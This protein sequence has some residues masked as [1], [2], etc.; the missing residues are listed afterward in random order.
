MSFFSTFFSKNTIA[1]AVE[2]SIDAVIKIDRHNKITYANP[3]AERL[4]GYDAKEMLGHNV[5]MLVPEEFRANHDTWVNANRET[6]VNKIVGTSREVQLQRKN[7]HRIWVT[8]SLSKVVVG[9]SIEYTAFVRDITDQK[10]QREIINQTL[11]Q[12][13][14]AVVTIDENNCITFYNPAAERLWGYKADEVMGKNVKMLV[15]IHHQPKHDNYVN[16]NRNT[17]IDKIVGTAREVQFTHR[18]G[19]ERWASLSLSKIQ[20][21]DRILYTAFLRDITEEV[22]RRERIR[23][24]SLVADETD[25]SVII[26]GPDRLI[27]YVNPGFVKLTGY[28]LEDV[29][30]KKPGD[31]LQGEATSKDTVQ[32][33]SANLSAKKPFYEEILNYSKEGE[34]YW[35]SLAINPVFDSAGELQNFVSIQANVTETKL[36]SLEF[37]YKLN[38]IDLTSATADFSINGEL[39]RANQ[40]LMQVFDVDSI[41]AFKSEAFSRLDG[42]ILEKC[43]SGQSEQREFQFY[44][45][46]GR[47]VWLDG[48]FAPIFDSLGQLTKIVF[49]GQPVTQRK[50]AI[51]AISHT[52]ASLAQGDLT[53]RVEGDFGNDLNIIRDNLNQSL[54]RLQQT[55]I[56]VTHASHSIGNSAN[57]ILHGNEDL[58][59][60]TEQQASSLEETAASMEQM[61]SSIRHSTDF[62]ER[63]NSVSRSAAD[64]AKEGGVIVTEAV[65]A[66]GEINRSS[67]QISDIV[68]VIDEIAFQTNLLALNASVEAARA[69]DQG[70][71]FAVV[72]SEVRNLAQRSAASA[73][74]I[75]DLIRDSVSK[76][77]AGTS[78]VNAS[79]DKLRDIVDSVTSVA[80]M[81]SQ[82][83]HS[84]KEQQ[85]GIEQVNTSVTQMDEMTQQNAALVEEASAASAAM[86]EQSNR[87]LSLMDFFK[88][89]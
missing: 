8:L 30:G 14:D 40:I 66:M 52:L 61:T 82:I 2:Q 48:A 56:E 51:D 44:T 5:K 88:V 23:L 28:E 71:G 34:P 42:S 81:V 84:A 75:K 3:A 33:I 79:G 57:E 76:V 46:Q 25:N 13:L 41:D 6:G 65:T 55:I 16:N 4:W 20:L 38:A 83:S 27:Q 67:N 19:T 37:N 17:G 74:E 22:E 32:R 31:L 77:E 26:T 73:K 50:Q 39:L 60:R 47:E 15:P 63:A 72:A 49:F 54:D 11:E 18:N 7:G 53:L 1:M 68:S 9:K 29:V 62:A 70:R 69:G 89:K 21:S 87:L 12:A 35:I 45:R 86:N 36:A 78:L 59:Q 64:T 80:E 10:N 85:S 58:S 43:A 24:L